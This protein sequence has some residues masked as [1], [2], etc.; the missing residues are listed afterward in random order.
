M[1]KW[2]FTTRHVVQVLSSVCDRDPV[3]SAIISNLTRSSPFF[4]L[5]LQEVEQNK[6][7]SWE[8][9]ISACLG[10]DRNPQLDYSLWFSEDPRLAQENSLSPHL[11]CCPILNNR[12]RNSFRKWAESISNQLFYPQIQSNKTVSR[13][14]AC[15][16]QKQVSGLELG[17]FD[18]DVSTASLERLYASSGLEV[19]GPCELRQ[20]WKYNDLTPRTYFAQGGTTFHASKYIRQVANTL[21]NSFPETNFQTRFSIN[22]VEVTSRHTTFIYDYSSFT[23]NLTELKYFLEALADFVDDI[24]IR[25]VDSR[26]GVLNQSLGSLIRAYN[27]DCNVQGE[28]SLQRYMDEDLSVLR[29]NRAGFLGVYGNIAFSTVLHGLH[30]ANVCSDSGGCRCV[31]DDAYGSTVLDE[32]FDKQKLITAIQS[33][34]EVQ[35]SKVNWWPFI[36]IEDET[37]SDHSW[38]Y[39][40]RPLDRVHNRMHLEQ[41]LFLPI[42]GLVN[43]IEDGIHDEP[44][45]VFTRVSILAQQS[46]SLIRQCKQ[47]HPPLDVGQQDLIRNY[48]EALYCAVG[49]PR[50]GRLP[51]ESFHI[52]GKQVS[53]ILLPNLEDGFLDCD[54]WDLLENRFVNRDTVL[55]TIPSSVLDREVLFTEVIR[56]KGNPVVTCMD[57]RLAYLERMEWITAKA[58]TEIRF[59]DFLE[60]RRFYDL[61]FAGALNRLY[62][63]RLVEGCPGWIDELVS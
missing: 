58:L 5:S 25:I 31:G 19:P 6:I 36:D 41:A 53:G 2:R 46:F 28:F 26:H 24:P 1:D 52:Q 38:A 51:F 9:E 33:I 63:V 42:F 12:I 11:R 47:L 50:E 23:S 16:F 8:K 30:A 49:C 57:R 61:L 43:P 10:P 27:Q 29:H 40:K 62:E 34:G 20:A 39:T 32:S 59:M 21:V 3:V 15:E 37:D 56:D 54:P 18:K 55:V 45:D 60:Y 48:L 13:M 7:D 22:D 17:S 35:S 44:E 14:T 4:G